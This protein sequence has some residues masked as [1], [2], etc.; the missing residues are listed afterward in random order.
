MLYAQH[1]FSP[2]S[3]DEMIIV[4]AI[5]TNAITTAHMHD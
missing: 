1:H 2:S 5:L 3:F 4:T